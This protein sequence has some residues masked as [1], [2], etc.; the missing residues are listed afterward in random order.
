M[1][2]VHCKNCS[3]LLGYYHVLV[4]QIK[5]KCGHT[6]EYRVLTE[7]FIKAVRD[8]EDIVHSMGTDVI[9]PNTIAV[10]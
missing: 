5:C 6:A 3:K 1:K 7:S 10:V 4:G 9:K 2:P 8:G